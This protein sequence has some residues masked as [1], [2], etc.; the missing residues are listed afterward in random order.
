[1]ARIWLMTAGLSLALALPLS[2]EYAA[3]PF[4]DG[5]THFSG[6]DIPS[7]IVSALA[8]LERENAAMVFFLPPPDT[9]D[10]P[11]LY[12]AEVILKAAREHKDKFAVLG[13]GGSL[14]PMI[15]QAVVSGDAGPAVRAK[16]RKRAEQLVKEGVVGFGEMTCEHFAGGT[17]YQY[18]PAD[19]PLFLL[20]ADI[21]AK[22]GKPIVLHM[23][24]VPR[25][26]PLPEELKSPPNPPEL[27]EN[28]AAFERLLAHN[29]KA[30]IIWAHAGTD[31]TGF[32]TPDLMRRLLQAHANLFMELKLDGSP[33]AKNPPLVDGKAA[34]DWLKLIQDFPDRFIMGTDQH[35]P[36]P[37]G[38]Q[39]WR[40]P[41]QFLNSLPDALQPFVAKKN[42]LRIY[43]MTK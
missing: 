23:E 9:F 14:N 19:H 1:M 33:A 11:K 17:P 35:Y 16:F 13:G 31:G 24:A 39:R 15:H 21:A 10:N 28:I 29:K 40:A 38:G 12:D 25:A 36:E 30:K 18:A 22:H 41:V 2:A 6:E 42:A 7:S 5:H 8:G 3:V 26:M 4:I 20:L 34:P 32:R 37:P 27:H 43:G